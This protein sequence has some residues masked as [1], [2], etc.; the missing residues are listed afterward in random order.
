MLAFLIACKTE[1]KSIMDSSTTNPDDVE[2][3]DQSNQDREPTSNEIESYGLFSAIEDGPYPMFI[4]TVEYP[5]K[6]SQAYF[7]LNIEQLHEELGDLL[8]MK[9]NYKTFYYIDSSDNL[10]MDMVYDG[11][12]LYGELDPQTDDNYKNITG[13]LSGAETETMGD[14]PNTIYITDASGKKMAFKEFITPEIV[15]QNG[16]TVTAYYYMKYSQDITYLKNS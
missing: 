9:G 12:S 5:E 11:K 8:A 6:Q 13:I 10:L 14:L 15:A 3:V 2:T 1:S 4:V 7:N 16:K